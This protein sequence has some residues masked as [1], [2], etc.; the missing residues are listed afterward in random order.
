MTKEYFWRTV[1]NGAVYVD[2]NSGDDMNGNG[3]KE[4]PYQT[5]GRAYRGAPNKPGTI[6]CRGYFSEDMAD[7][8]H[9]C[10]IY[11]EY[12]GAAVFDGKDIYTLYGFTMHNLIVE[13]CIPGNSTLTV[14]SNNSLYAGVGR[15]VG[16]GNVGN[17]NNA[18]YFPGVA[19][20]KCVIKDCGHYFGHIGGSGNFNVISNPKHNDTYPLFLWG[21]TNPY[22]WCIHGVK[23]EDRTKSKNSTAAGNN[24]FKSIFTDVAFYINDHISFNGCYFG[25]DCTWWDNNTDEQI[26]LEGETSE[27]K[28]AFLRSKMQELGAANTNCTLDDECVFLDKTAS[29]IYNN[30]ELGDFTTKLDSGIP[31]SIGTFGPALNIAIKDSDE[32]PAGSDVT[33]MWDPDSNINNL[34]VENNQIVLTNEDSD[35]VEDSSI[36]TGIIM[37]DVE[38]YS[39]KSLYAEMASKFDKK[40]SLSE[41]DIIGE[42]Y[43]AGTSLPVGKYVVKGDVVYQDL[44]FTEGDILTVLEEDTQFQVSPESGNGK[45]LELLNP[46]IEVL[47]YVRSFQS[48]LDIQESTNISLEDGKLY[49]VLEA[50]G[51]AQLSTGRKIYKGSVIEGANGVSVTGSENVRLATMSTVNS[52]W[53]PLQ[54]WGDV[55]IVKDGLKIQ[56]DSDGVPLSSGNANTYNPSTNAGTYKYSAYPISYR[57][58]QFKIVARKVC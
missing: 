31:D 55:F 17:A 56:K 53:C 26:I 42:P 13:N 50:P 49:M 40:V 54:T 47:T 41:K 30:H 10:Q 21:N 20:S 32:L 11:G 36:Y 5:L 48:I 16:A 6:V 3:T 33:N 57:Y 9:S 46:N 25:S 45:L 24:F 39:I 43:E 35:T 27:E 8:N 58:Q 19:G 2:S 7:G 4:N 22:N 37:I 38:K 1:I 34:S 18:S 15:A 12:P 44:P 51:T 52:E 29:E 28:L 23:K 14:A